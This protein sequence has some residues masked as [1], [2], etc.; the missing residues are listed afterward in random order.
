M[1]SLKS[2]VFIR[3]HFLKN[4]YRYFKHHRE[5]ILKMTDELVQSQMKM[6]DWARR[7]K[8]AFSRLPFFPIDYFVSKK[9]IEVGTGKIS[10]LKAAISK[11]CKQFKRECKQY[12]IIQEIMRKR[13][14]AMILL[15][16]WYLFSNQTFLC[17]SLLET[18]QF[19]HLIETKE[20][21]RW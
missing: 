13:P 5:A 6:F 3:E 17:I 11:H 2:S 15:A 10:K 14:R 7:G 16:F 9:F 4:H 18:N 1:I 20:S 19:L 8:F 12:K 21:H